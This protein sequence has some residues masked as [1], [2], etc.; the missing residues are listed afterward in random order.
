MNCNSYPFLTFIGIFGSWICRDAGVV[1]NE[2]LIQIECFLSWFSDRSGC[3]CG[4]WFG[5]LCR[6]GN[7][8]CRS[9]GWI[10]PVVFF[11]IKR[12]ILLFPC[13]VH[14]TFVNIL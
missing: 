14:Y 8:L 11:V 10:I 12:Q 9:W 1:L 5:Y 2:F 6:G 7:G 3:Y 13:P 4:S